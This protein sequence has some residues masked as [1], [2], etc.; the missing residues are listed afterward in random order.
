M[1][2][3]TLHPLK[4]KSLSVYMQDLKK[5]KLGTDL[6]IQHASLYLENIELGIHKETEA[7]KAY[8]SIINYC[9]KIKFLKLSWDNNN[10]SQIYKLISHLNHLKYLSFQNY[11]GNGSTI[12]R[13]LGQILPAS[14]RYLELYFEMDPNDLKIFLNNC[15][16]I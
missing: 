15:K 2:T 8:E 11:G 6:L 14:L 4:I 12:L 7:R 16:H 9:D 13:G 10:I 1:T 5:D 3:Q